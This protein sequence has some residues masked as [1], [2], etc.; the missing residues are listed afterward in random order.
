MYQNIHNTHPNKGSRVIYTN[1]GYTAHLII[2]LTPNFVESSCALPPIFEVWRG[3][4]KHLTSTHKTL[5]KKE[6]TRNFSF[7]ANRHLILNIQK[8]KIM[9]LIIFIQNVSWM[10]THDSLR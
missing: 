4:V 3:A 1:T 10:C 7:D 9:L 6:R 5:C 8:R 2:H